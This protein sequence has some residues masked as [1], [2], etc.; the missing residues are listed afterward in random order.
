MSLERQLI[1]QISNLAWD[2]DNLSLVQIVSKIQGYLYEY[3]AICDHASL[4]QEQHHA[5]MAESF[6]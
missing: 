6:E 4:E 2:T 1:A 3:E 5:E